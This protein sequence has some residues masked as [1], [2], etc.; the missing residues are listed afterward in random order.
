MVKHVQADG[1]Q[2]W[3]PK[4]ARE[5]EEIIRVRVIEEAAIA[6]DRFARVQALL[7]EIRRNHALSHVARHPS[8]CTS[9][10]RCGFCGE[11][12]YVTANGKKGKTGH[13]YGY[14]ICKS[15]VP[16]RK[17]KL[18]PCNNSWVRRENLDA[19]LEAFCQHTL[20]RSELLVAIIEGSARRSAQVIRAFQP[21]TKDDAIR[22]L[23]QRDERLMAMCEAQTISIDEFRARRTKVR[24]EIARLEAAAETKGP[25]ASPAITLTEFARQ[26]TK[27]F[28]RCG[29]IG[30]SAEKKQILRDLFAEVFF[31]GESISAFRFSKSFLTELGETSLAA[32]TVQL[33]TPF[34]IRE[35]PQPLP[36]GHKHCNCCGRVRPLTDFYPRR[37]RCRECFKKALNERRRE[38]RRAQK[39]A[40]SKIL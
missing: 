36:E 8:L 1:R 2:G 29:R 37:A 11:P 9:I 14:Y 15:R 3:R 31:R 16:G 28:I 30:S 32:Q 18:T 38:R 12:L 4:K 40:D 39:A 19:L 34:R 25:P 27:A 33:S 24:E 6:P 23:R 21:P 5:V 22:K 7:S 35:L 10:G 17:G 26:V 20:T 13:N